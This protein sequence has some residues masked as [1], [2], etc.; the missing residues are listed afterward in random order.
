VARQRVFV[1]AWLVSAAT[2]AAGVLTYAFLILA[3]RTLGPHAYGRVAALWA[4]IFIGAVVLY[5]PLE[6]TASRTIADRLASGGDARSVLRALASVGALAVALTAAVVI[7]A[8]RPL[9]ARVFLGD[10]TLTLLLLFGTVAYGLS[11]LARGLVGGVR[12]FGGY[13]VV[14][15]ADGLARLL[16]AAPL[17]LVAS[18][19][20]AGASMVA[21]G[22]A[23]AVVPFAFGRK[24]MRPVL[25]GRGSEPLEVRTALAFAAPATAIAAA[26]Q[27]LVNG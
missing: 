21:A 18:A 13:A 23:G 12:W 5:R 10:R 16:V 25:A 7:V 27:L 17:L 8:W 24:R 20:L 19:H 22:V 2:A 1:G 15:L 6:Q 4:A 26:D 14:L 11:Y 3:A 9:T